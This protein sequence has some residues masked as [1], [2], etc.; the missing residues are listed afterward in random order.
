[1]AAVLRMY[2]EVE[3]PVVKKRETRAVGQPEM[4]A[5]QP[6]VLEPQL[7]GLVERVVPVGADAGG[8]NAVEA[9]LDVRV[10]RLD[11]EHRAETSDSDQAST[12]VGAVSFSL[13]GSTKR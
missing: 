3:R 8:P 6:V 9:V 7:R 11:L 10:P 13:A 1:M 2:G 4:C 5:A 12:F